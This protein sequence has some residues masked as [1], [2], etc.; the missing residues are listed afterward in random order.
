MANA[1]IE[2]FRELL[3]TELPRGKGRMSDA[4]KRLIPLKEDIQKAREMRFGYKQIAE[5]LHKAGAEATADSVRRFCK[6]V[7]KEETKKR[8]RAKSGAAKPDAGKAAVQ[9]DAIQKPGGKPGFRVA[10][11][12]L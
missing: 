7:L 1:Q 11:D 4:I 3:N 6:I 9:T 12:D 2:R 10:R 5:M 8:R